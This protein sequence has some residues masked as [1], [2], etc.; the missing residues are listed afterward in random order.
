MRLAFCFI[1][2]NNTNLMHLYYHFNYRMAVPPYIIDS[3]T[4]NVLINPPLNYHN[5][6]MDRWNVK[7]KCYESFAAIDY[8]SIRQ[9]SLEM[10]GN[11]DLIFVGDDDFKF[12][13]GSSEAINECCLYMERNKDCGAILLGANWGEEGK[14]HE[15]EVYITNK[16][17]LNTNRGIILR[18]R[19]RLR[20]MNNGFHALGAMED[21]VISFTCLLDGYYIARRLHVP[22]EHIV[23]RNSLFPGNTNQNYDLDFVRKRGIWSKV[24][25]TLGS[26]E[27]QNIWPMGIWQHYRQMAMVNGFLLTY[28]IDGTIII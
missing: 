12:N 4:M 19:D 9:D 10:A 26:W 24:V 21:S 1:S 6:K 17:H 16:G 28:D 25:K 22:I 20:L 2:N 3:Y 23:E 15:N 14:L 5:V 7:W 18:N 13:E 8:F 11:A 27:D